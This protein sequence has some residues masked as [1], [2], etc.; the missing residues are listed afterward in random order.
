[1]L[2]NI[3]QIVYIPSCLTSLKQV[4]S[5]LDINKEKYETT[6]RK[7]LAII[8]SKRKTPRNFDHRTGMLLP[9]SDFKNVLKYFTHEEKSVL[10]SSVESSHHRI[11]IMGYYVNRKVRRK[12]QGLNTWYKKKDVK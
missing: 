8:N 12:F 6:F 4:Y 11:S 2:V 7:E 9:I 5:Y 10:I 1:M 3:L